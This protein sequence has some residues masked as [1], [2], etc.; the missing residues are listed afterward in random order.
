MD[1]RDTPPQHRVPHNIKWTSFA[2]PG[3]TN[4]AP[5]LTEMALI[6]DEP[7]MANANALTK[8]VCIVVPGDAFKD[9]LKRADP[10]IGALLPRVCPKHQ[11]NRRPQAR[12]RPGMMHQAAPASSD[13]RSRNAVIDIQK[14]VGA[15]GFEP[16]TP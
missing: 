2:P 3:W 6:D 11:I 5:P 4:F 13:G 10:F 1:Y 16:A 14:L 8:T 9:K 12:Q 15:A 7:R